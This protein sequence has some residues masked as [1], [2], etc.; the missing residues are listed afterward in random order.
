MNT[1]LYGLTL[2]RNGLK[3]DYP[4]KE[5]LAALTDLCEQSFIALGDSEDGTEKEVQKFEN[6]TIIPT[7][8]DM[9]LMGDGGKILSQQT[10]VALEA[11]RKEYKTGWGFYLQTDELIHEKDFDQIKKDILAAEANGC[12][13][14]RFRYFHFWLNHNQIAISKRWYPQEIRAIKLDSN[15]TSHGDAQGFIGQQKVYE[16]DVHIFH[17]G[18]V[19][20]E[21]KREAKQELLIKMIR[22]DEKFKKY[23]TRE[24]KAFKK[25]ETLPYYGPHPK[26]MKE[27]I[28]K[29]GDI[30]EMPEKEHVLIYD[31]RGII[32][33]DL[34]A[35]IRTKKLEIIKKDQR[36]AL[37]LEPTFL[38]GLGFGKRIP[39][40]MKSPI[41]RAWSEKQRMEFLLWSKGIST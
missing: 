21:E 5:C 20:D 15:I 23:K 8:W 1:T 12:D 9:S 13:A 39:Q 25:T 41:A 31:P 28:T 29:F 3:Y 6:L 22:P 26:W 14:I 35:R 11:L 38:E 37:S 4:F 34:K 18:H 2:L 33:E 27:R 10:N 32:D 30:F 36:E 17:Y 7:T 40:G 19:R 24:E 16:S